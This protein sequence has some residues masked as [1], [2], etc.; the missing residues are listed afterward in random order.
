MAHWREGRLPAPDGLSLYYQSW[1][2]AQPRAVVVVVHGLAEHSGR[3]E[4][5]GHSLTQAGLAVYAPDQ[6]GPAS[7]PGRRGRA[8]APRRLRADVVR[9][10]RGHARAEHRRKPL[11]LPGRSRGRPRRRN[12]GAARARRSGRPRPSSPSSGSLRDR[13]RP[14]ARPRGAPLAALAPRTLFPST[15]DP[16]LLSRDAAVGSPT[17]LMPWS[18]IRLGRLVPGGD[19][20][21]GG[22]ARGRARAP[23]PD[24]SA[25]CGGRCP[26]RSRGHRPVAG[27][28]PEGASGGVLLRRLLSRDPERSRE[29]PSLEADRGLDLKT[30]Q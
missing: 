1:Q 29:G 16:S 7:R 30:N 9:T 24:P 13:D 2:P 22:G 18:A 23:S 4:A 19:V 6:R 28:G 14:A 17:P 11:F 12:P 8:P 26:R 15:V 21:P 27:T 3:Y 25:L 10:G 5:V 20:A